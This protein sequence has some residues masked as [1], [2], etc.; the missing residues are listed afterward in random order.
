[1]PRVQHKGV[2]KIRINLSKILVD[3]LENSMKETRLT[4][5]NEIT[6]HLYVFFKLPIPHELES[7]PILEITDKLIRIGLPQIIIDSLEKSVEESGLDI[8]DQ[9]KKILYLEFKLPIP[10]EMEK[11][12]N[13]TMFVNSALAQIEKID[14]NCSHRK[15]ELTRLSDHVSKLLDEYAVN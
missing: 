2:K 6:K 9:V 10:R 12:S 15:E 11:P 1:M 13:S 4:I 7:P 14:K 3:H 8:H 5:Y